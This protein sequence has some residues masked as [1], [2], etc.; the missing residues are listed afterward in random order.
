M[1]P[2]VRQHDYEC[3]RHVQIR[4]NAVRESIANNTI[5]VHYIAAD[6]TLADLY[7]KE[8]CDI[9]HFQSLRD[10]IMTSRPD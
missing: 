6:V 7:K 4:G 10:T 1:C 5:S 3:L 9:N 2:V 8:D